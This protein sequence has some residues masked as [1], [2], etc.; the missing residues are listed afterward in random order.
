M[1]REIGSFSWC[2]QGCPLSTYR[3][4]SWVFQKSVKNEQYFAQ[5]ASNGKIEWLWLFYHHRR[6]WQTWGWHPQY[7]I[8][9]SVFEIILLLRQIEVFFVVVSGKRRMRSSL[10]VRIFF[11]DFFSFFEKKIIFPFKNEPG[12]CTKTSMINL[13]VFLSL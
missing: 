2:C 7:M 6:N 3:N 12:N 8:N 4:Y 13:K 5:W 11:I 9:P 10:M 1:A